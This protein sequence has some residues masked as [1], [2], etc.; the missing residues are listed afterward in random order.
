[1]ASI[2]GLIDPR[3][4]ELRYIGKANDARKRFASH[5]RDSI[6]RNTPVY[7]WFGK[8]AELGLQP[9]MVVLSEC[10]NWQ[11]EER[12]LIAS[13][14]MRGYH[15]LNVADGGDEPHCPREVRIA[16]ACRAAQDRERDV[17]KKT[18]HRFMRKAGYALEHFVE[19]GEAGRAQQIMAALAVL[20]LRAKADPALLYR[21]IVS[22]EART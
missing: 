3:T 8:L 12:R 21:Q 7:A 9:D 11:G 22:R 19:K 6:R 2:Y 14:R 1:M 16:N 15:L 20:K 13:A 18:I 17:V 4:G 5:L 10:E